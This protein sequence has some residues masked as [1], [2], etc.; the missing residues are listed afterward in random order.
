MALFFSNYPEAEREA[1]RLST[2]LPAYMMYT[3]V[4][5]YK[6]IPDE[7]KR[8]VTVVSEP[9]AAQQAL[10]MLAWDEEEEVGVMNEGQDAATRADKAA[11]G[12]YFD[13]DLQDYMERDEG[14]PRVSRANMAAGLEF[15]PDAQSLGSMRTVEYAA[16]GTSR[17]RERAA[18]KPLM[19]GVEGLQKATTAGSQALV[20]GSARSPA[21]GGGTA[22]SEPPPSNKPGRCGGNG[23]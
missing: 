4:L 20:E 2:H 21:N 14:D 9:V 13:F 12:H 17:A 23:E 22:R 16:R 19:R 8:F 3:L 7:A 11:E 15:D 5:R 6:V 1:I 18:P 10:N